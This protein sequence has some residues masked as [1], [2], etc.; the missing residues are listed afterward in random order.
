LIDNNWFADIS[1][2]AATVEYGTGPVSIVALGQVGTKITNNFFRRG[3]YYVAPYTEA[4]EFATKAFAG[5]ISGNLIVDFTNGITLYEVGADVRGNT[6][7]N[8]GGGRANDKMLRLRPPDPP[9]PTRM[10]R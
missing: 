7:F 2:A 8:T 1:A 9:R 4:I 5:K 3:P 10:A 6:L